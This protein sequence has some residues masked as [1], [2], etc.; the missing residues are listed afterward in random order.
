MTLLTEDKLSLNHKKVN[1]DSITLPE[2]FHHFNFFSVKKISD[3]NTLK[4]EYL[5]ELGREANF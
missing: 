3:R 4:F 5:W 1:T 2:G